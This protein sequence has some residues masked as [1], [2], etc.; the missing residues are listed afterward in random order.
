MQYFVKINST[1]CLTWL[2]QV[3]RKRYLRKK[4]KRYLRKQK[5]VILEKKLSMTFRLS[6]YVAKFQKL[7]FD[8]NGLG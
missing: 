4:K 3:Y 1:E 2:S 6:N 5:N 7:Q 8:F